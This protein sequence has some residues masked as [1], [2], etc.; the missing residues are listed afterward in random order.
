[1]ANQT[2][3][4]GAANEATGGTEEGAELLKN[5]V[6]V[7]FREDLDAAALVLGREV[8]E[9]KRMLDGDEV[10]DEDLDMKIRGIAQERNFEI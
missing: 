3:A 4:A 8:D 1:M 7:G 2:T 6:A 10:V 5:F 9:I